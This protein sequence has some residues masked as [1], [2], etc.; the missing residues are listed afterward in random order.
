[1]GLSGGTE[2][3]TNVEFLVYNDN[4]EA[5]STEFTFRSWEKVSL[6]D[7]SGIFNQDFLRDFTGH[8]PAEVMGSR[9]LEAGWF[10][11]TGR[12]ANS[13]DASIQDPAVYGFLLERGGGAG[14]ADLPF[15]NGSRVGH[16]LPDSPSGDNE[17]SS[18]WN[19]TAPSEQVHRRTP[20]SLLLYPEFDN[21]AGVISILTVTNAG[22]AGV[23]ARFVYYGR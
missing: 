5:F 21:H 3:D 8:D 19:G 6:L 22:D 7:I 15:E 4:E 16:L 10:R 20:G 14:A 17:E 13:A 18:G 1:M 12:V 2:F 9:D 23:T 11:M